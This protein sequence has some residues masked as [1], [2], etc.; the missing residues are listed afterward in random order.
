MT[1]RFIKFL[2]YKNLLLE[3]VFVLLHKRL[4]LGM[5]KVIIE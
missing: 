4:S 1:E 3:F 2:F 5:K